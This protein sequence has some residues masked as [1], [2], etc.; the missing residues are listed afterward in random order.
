MH[1]DFAGPFQDT[2][3]LVVVDVHTKW[4]YIF[5]MRNTTVAETVATLRYLFARMD[6]PEQVVSDNGPQFVAYPTRAWRFVA[7]THQRLSGTHGS[8]F[9]ERCQ[10]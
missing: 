4:T 3:F 6:L 10:S 1:I 8:K 9:Q 2:M 7:S 5:E